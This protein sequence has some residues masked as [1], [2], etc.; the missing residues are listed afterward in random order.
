MLDSLVP[1]NEH[2]DEGV[3][4]FS[5]TARYTIT[6]RQKHIDRH[7]RYVLDIGTVYNL[8][9]VFVNGQEVAHLWKPPFRCDVTDVLH[10]G[11]N[12]LEVEV[13]NLW[14]NRMIGDEQYEDDVEWGEPL[15]YEYASGN[16][17]VGRFM[18]RIPDW[19]RL[20]HPR[21]SAKRKT[22]VSFKYF[23]KDSSLLPSGMLG[24]VKIDV[25]Q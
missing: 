13:T 9:R 23:D 6:F 10:K 4:Y 11:K 15:H 8:A 7:S 21:P 12:T 17:I 25:E 5:G 14:P 24:P 3:K 1:W 16:P 22:V 20:G 18:A 2:T 19:L